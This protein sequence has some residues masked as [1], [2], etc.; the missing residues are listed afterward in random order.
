MFEHLYTK[1][2][3]YYAIVTLKV[4]GA[5]AIGITKAFRLALSAQEIKTEEIDV[6]KKVVARLKE[7]LYRAR[8][9]A[10]NLAW[11]LDTV[12]ANKNANSIFCGSTAFDL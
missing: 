8:P 9:T 6:F 2:D 3:V 5:P 10:V 12:S 1:E 11:A 7:Y 4:C